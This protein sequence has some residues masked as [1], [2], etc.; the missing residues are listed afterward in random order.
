M[1]E[2]PSPATLSPE[3]SGPRGYEH[4]PTFTP[5]TAALEAAHIVAFDNRDIRSRPFNIMRTRV[6][7]QMD[8]QKMRMI[9]VTSPAPTAGKSLISLNLAAAIAR[10]NDQPVILADLDLRR[11]TLATALD[12]QFEHGLTDFL[13]G[14]TQ[15]LD[16]VAV[17]IADTPLVLL[18]SHVTTEDSSALLSGPQFE[19]LIDWLRMQAQ[20]AVVIVDL[21]PVFAND[22]AMILMER[23]DGYLMVVDSG[24]TTSRQVR[25]ALELLRP[26]APLGTVLNRYEGGM[27]D[28]YGYGPSSAYS[29]YYNR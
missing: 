29:K 26:S 6:L 17:R 2:M 18:P 25:D 1:T 13:E 9:G 12:Y 19:A 8:L 11:G 14:R 27:L 4:L 3:T 10:L 23:L 24:K 20:Q 5:S 15:S 7:K 16:Q 22:D 21:P 28:S